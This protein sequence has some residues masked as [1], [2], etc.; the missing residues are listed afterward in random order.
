MP[1]KTDGWSAK[2]TRSITLKNG[3]NLVT[4]ADVR[5][6]ILKEPDHIQAAPSASGRPCLFSRNLHAVYRNAEHR[7][8]V[9]ACDMVNEF[10]VRFCNCS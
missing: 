4:L 6:F 10:L 8:G 1:G 5:A 7:I 9:L 2:L 3:T